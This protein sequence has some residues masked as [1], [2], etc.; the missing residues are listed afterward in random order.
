MS[1]RN[2][3]WSALLLAGLAG[4][5]SSEG[6]SVPA[7]GT[8]T[9]LPAPSDEAQAKEKSKSIFKLNTPGGAAPVAGP[10]G[11]AGSAP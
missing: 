9:N 6:P 1:V 8:A 11:S 10:A 2:L 3:S 5:E 7:A 4:C